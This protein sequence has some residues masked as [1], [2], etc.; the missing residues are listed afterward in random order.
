MKRL[1]INGKHLGNIPEN[2][3]EMTPIQIKKL[4]KL[5]STNPDEK[6]LRIML[7]MVFS[8]LFFSKRNFTTIDN[9]INHWYYS[10][11]TGNFLLPNYVVEWA[12][13]SFDWLF[14]NHDGLFYIE[15]KMHVNNL[16]IL[17]TRF[18]RKLHGPESALFNITWLEFERLEV[19]Y[20]RLKTDEKAMDNLIGILYRPM[21]P[22][23]KRKPG[24]DPRVD[25]N[26]H[27]LA[28]YAR[29][30]KWLRPW[31]KIYIKLFYE[32]CRAF[33]IEK[34]P[35]AFGKDG[36]TTEP[37]TSLTQQF[38]SLT[39]A[40]ANNNPLNAAPMR[41]TRLWDILPAME[42]TAKTAKELKAAQK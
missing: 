16:P 31:Q 7:L 15:S 14:K 23:P 22:K 20:D 41:Q 42:A 35:N 5:L 17:F 29:T 27:D 4:C 25:Y 6:T 19:N 34:H 1:E 40:L 24:V 39:N 37:G 10:R 12:V 33:I 18:C 21:K 36:S 8:N 13:K 28:K 38:A 26:D 9:E 32:G 2:W 11:K 30:A 3:R